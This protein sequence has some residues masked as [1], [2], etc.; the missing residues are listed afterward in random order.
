[1]LEQALS[2]H[3]HSHSEREQEHEHSASSCSFETITFPKSNKDLERLE[4]QAR[5]LGAVPEKGV[6]DHDYDSLHPPAAKKAK[7]G[8]YYL[9]S[10]L[11]YEYMFMSQDCECSILRVRI[12]LYC[13]V[14][15][16]H[17]CG[18]GCE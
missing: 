17:G 14:V 10:V 3:S 6:H 9:C 7:F 5:R 11:T 12:C 8:M 2:D 18:C 1:M 15:G 13:R 16:W 4:R